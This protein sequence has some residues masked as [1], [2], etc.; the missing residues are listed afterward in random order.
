MVEVAQAD[1]E[2]AAALCRE[3]DQAWIA[4]GIDAGTRD[5]F[6]WVQA[7]ARHREA[8]EAR[9]RDEEWAR[10]TS[11]LAMTELVNIETA[12]VDWLAG[13][14]TA[15]DTVT[16]LA[17]SRVGSSLAGDTG[18]NTAAIRSAE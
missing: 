18:S 4:E 15:M 13:F 12:P 17:P 10:I 7:F 16:P 14:R 6:A 3:T 9:G 2:A 11:E 1:R 5:R 8:A